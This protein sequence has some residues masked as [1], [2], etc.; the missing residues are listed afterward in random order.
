VLC[1]R[2]SRCDQVPE[3][4]ADAAGSDA[5]PGVGLGTD[6]R[7]ESRGVTGLA[8]ALNDQILHVSVF[9]RANGDKRDRNGSRM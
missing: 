4:R 3:G 5:R 7:I 8:L 2:Y 1:E 6:F 9:A